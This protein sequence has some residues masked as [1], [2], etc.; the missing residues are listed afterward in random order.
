MSNNFLKSVLLITATQIIMSS[1]CKREGTTRPCPSSTPYSFNVTSEFS[2]QRENY[3]VGDTIFLTSSFAN[4]LINN[5]TNQLIDYS[6]SVGIGGTINFYKLDTI[7]KKA[8][9]AF[10][11][12]NTILILGNYSQFSTTPNEGISSTYS[13]TINYSFKIGIVLR[14]KGIF[15]LG[16]NDLKS[17]GIKNKNCTNAG[18]NMV[19]SNSNKN[20]NLFQ[21]ALGYTPD[22]LLLK[23]IYCFRVR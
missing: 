16:V 12:F 21:Y 5:V 18:F 6:N 3:N 13:E 2:P 7:T 9:G 20:I 23:N 19:V 14:Q 10:T 8:T 11:E 1:G 17:Q 15:L 22:A 4:N